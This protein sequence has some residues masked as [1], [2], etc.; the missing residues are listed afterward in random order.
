MDSTEPDIR[1]GDSGIC[2][3][4]TDWLERIRNETFVGHP[5]RNIHSLISRIKEVGRGREFDCLIAVS[6][7]VDSALTLPT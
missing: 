2:N 6:G 3:F 1:F 7:G 4:H 5:T